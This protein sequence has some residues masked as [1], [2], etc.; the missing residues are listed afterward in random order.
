MKFTNWS[1]RIAALCVLLSTSLTQALAV[2]PTVRAMP[3]GIKTPTQDTAYA[4]AG[5][6]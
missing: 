4:W 2:G 5:N 3:D 6:P 1:C